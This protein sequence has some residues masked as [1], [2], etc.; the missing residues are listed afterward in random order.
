MLY[1]CIYPLRVCQS[2]RVISV[3]VRLTASV[4]HV[5]TNKDDLVAS[6]L[7]SKVYSLVAAIHSSV[8]QPLARRKPA[9]WLHVN[10]TQSVLDFAPLV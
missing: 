5:V 4:L 10:T 2:F 1:P 8:Q 7:V 9:P 3:P 6:K